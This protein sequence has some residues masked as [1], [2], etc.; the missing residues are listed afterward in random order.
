MKSLLFSML[1]LLAFA[2]LAAQS[3]ITGRITN[4]ETG[5][6]LI[7]ANIVVQDQAKGAATGADGSFAISKVHEGSHTLR[8]S[9]VGF[10]TLDTQIT[11]TAP[12][13]LN[14]QLQPKPYFSEE[15]VVE[16]TRFSEEGPKTF[17]TISKK[18]ITEENVGRD[19]PFLLNM[20]PSVVANS[21][22]GNG[23]GY[24]GIRIRGLDITRINVTLNGV[25]V[26]DAESQGVFFVDLPDLAASVEN[27]QIQRGVGT[28]TNGSAAFGSS[29]NIQTS[30]I[31]DQPSAELSGSYGSFNSY[32]GSVNFSTG[33]MD[34]NWGFQ[35]RLS[36]I[37]SDGYVDRAYSDLK[38]AYLSGGYFG[39]R[40]ILKFVVLTGVEETYQAWCGTPEAALENNRTMN[41]CGTDYGSKPGDPYEGET[42][43]YQQDYYQL[44]FSHRF[45][46]NFFGNA[47]VFLTRGRGYY[48]EYKV[49][50]YLPDYAIAPITF[51]GDTIRFR[52]SLFVNNDTIVN[53]SGEDTSV[54]IGG[55]TVTES[56]LIRRR[57]LDNY[58]YGTILSAN[59]KASE[60]TD[61]TFG[62]SALRYE[63]RHF[64]E[65]IW[66][67]QAGESEIRHQYYD[68]DA[69]K[70]EGNIF[71]KLD[72]NPRDNLLLFGELQSRYIDYTLLG[73]EGDPEANDYNTSYLFVNPKAGAVYQFNKKN[74]GYIYYGLSHREPNRNDFQE[75]LPQREPQPERLHDIEGGYV[76]NSPLLQLSANGY[77]MYFTDQLIPT[78]EIN[79]VGGLVRQNID[80]SYRAGVELEAGWQPY[81]GLQWQ[82][83]ATFSQNKIREFNEVLYTYNSETFETVDTVVNTYS[84][85]DIAFSPD[86]IL[87]S[88]LSYSFARNFKATHE[89]KYVGRQY[90]DNT[91]TE[92]RS[93][94]PFLVNNLRLQY[95]NEKIPGL[96][97]LRLT[98]QI[99]NFLNELYEANGY[100]FSTSEFN[101]NTANTTRTD[102]NYYYPMA[103]T[104]YWAGIV[105]GL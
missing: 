83:A 15:V 79:D 13:V 58:Y 40:S 24:T 23:V 36:K 25:P 54:V 55:E 93:I 51:P 85:T 9:Y 74:K 87:A 6:P 88:Q 47:S 67:R 16:V 52:D 56:D 45:S 8:V 90:L 99:N 68:N 22:A 32:R 7:G 72:L 64:G 105:L 10:Q 73:F 17:S 12:M 53:P 43:N 96:K 38:S 19:L 34:N 91:S 104:N 98:F 71:A 100:T 101:P 65:V 102:Y 77:Y 76:F 5:E 66:A 4:A 48:E 29:I 89:T 82:V 2:G 3:Q 27:I 33:K 75:S 80:N 57:W 50:Q 1:A 63:G 46:E 20:T 39:T 61:V 49:D 41:L 78:G 60:N 14:L 35:G 70:D 18:E 21:D 81:R 42:D 11:V 95:L 37:S 97:S 31:G 92:S 59:W 103:T 26:N 62:A 69:L 44:H 84:N 28:S 86:V 94:A 30:Q